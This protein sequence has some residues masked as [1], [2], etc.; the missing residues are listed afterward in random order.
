MQMVY[1]GSCAALIYTGDSF[2]YFKKP[3]DDCFRGRLRPN[4]GAVRQCPRFTPSLARA[5]SVY[6]DF[7]GEQETRWG[8][9]AK[10]LPAT[11]EM[12][13]GGAFGAA[14]GLPLVAEL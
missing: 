3:I 14:R 8:R 11:S 13:Y 5:M 9:L 2:S 6:L 7:Q 10:H 1:S 12:F 4:S